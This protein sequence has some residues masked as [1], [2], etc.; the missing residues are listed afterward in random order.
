MNDIYDC[1]QKPIWVTEFAVAAW[2]SNEYWHP[3]DGNMNNII[4]LFKNL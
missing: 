2:D 4:K 3:Y 1:Y